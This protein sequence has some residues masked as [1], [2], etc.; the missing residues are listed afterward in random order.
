MT[1]QTKS[2]P[3]APRYAEVEPIT[4]SVLDEVLAA[5]EEKLAPS[6]VDSIL[7]RVSL[8]D[9]LIAKGPE[10]FGSDSNIFLNLVVTR[11]I[12]DVDVIDP[13]SGK[14]KATFASVEKARDGRVLVPRC[15]CGKLGPCNVVGYELA[16]VAP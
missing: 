10:L 16:E 6:P 12:A 13:V 9:P 5:T 2:L 4:T 3:L 1:M 14:I 8:E 15:A 7:S 11:A